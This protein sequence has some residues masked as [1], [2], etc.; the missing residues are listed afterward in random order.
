MMMIQN[1]INN[2]RGHGIHSKII[3]HKTVESAPAPQGHLGAH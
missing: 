3:Q 1:I 2:F